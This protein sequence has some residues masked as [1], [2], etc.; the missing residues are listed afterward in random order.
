LGLYHYQNWKRM[1][2]YTN[3]LAA[4][5]RT[6]AAAACDPNNADVAFR[7]LV[8]G[9]ARRQHRRRGESFV[10]RFPRSRPI[11]AVPLRSRRGV[12]TRAHATTRTRSTS[13]TTPRALST[14]R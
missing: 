5:R 7:C 12:M 8:A 10:A 2:E 6:R 14:N 13:S 11:H 1:N 4:A 3:D 9:Y